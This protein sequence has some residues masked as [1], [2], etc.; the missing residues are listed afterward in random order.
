M[1]SGINLSFFSPLKPCN[2]KNGQSKVT[3]DYISQ[4]INL[5]FVLISLLN[6]VS[7]PSKWAL[8]QFYYNV[9]LKILPTLLEVILLH[10]F[11]SCHEDGYDKINELSKC[12]LVSFS[13]KTELLLRNKA[14][15]KF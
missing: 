6:L 12:G 9:H 14:Q 13:T 2:T 1:S 11:K 15:I 10:L 5:N 3:L 8:F 4:L 7:K